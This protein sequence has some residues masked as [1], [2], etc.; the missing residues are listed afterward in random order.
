MPRFDFRCTECTYSFE[1]TIP[2]GA[3]K[4]PKCKKCGGKTQKLIAPPAIHF[5]GSGFYV[6]DTVAKKPAE[7]KEGKKSAETSSAK[8]EKKGESS[9]VGGS[10]KTTKK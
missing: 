4:W 10:D 7:K 3:K 6:T 1:A 2:F 5:K 8:P 9:S